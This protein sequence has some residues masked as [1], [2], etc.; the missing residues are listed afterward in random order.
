MV[1]GNR[2]RFLL[3]LD[4]F[5]TITKSYPHSLTLRTVYSRSLGVMEQSEGAAMLEQIGKENM[6]KCLDG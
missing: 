2:Q 6:S 1:R 4:L 5:H 3:A